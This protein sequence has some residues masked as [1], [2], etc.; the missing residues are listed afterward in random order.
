MWQE[1]MLSTI[2]EDTLANQESPQEQ[3]EEQKQNETSCVTLD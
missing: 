2:Y 1:V 3:L